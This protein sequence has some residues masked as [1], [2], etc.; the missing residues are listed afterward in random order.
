MTIEQTVEHFDA[1][2]VGAGISG[3]AAGYHLQANC[4]GRTYAIL[5]RRDQI[6]GTWEALLST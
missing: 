3:I 2:I 1:L 6:G 5:E 4:P